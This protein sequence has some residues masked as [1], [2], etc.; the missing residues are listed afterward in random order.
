MIRLSRRHLLGAAMTAA[1]AGCGPGEWLVGAAAAAAGT[2]PA[3]G[4]TVDFARHVL[5]RC[6]FGARAGDRAALLARG[7]PAWLDGQ[8]TAGGDRAMERLLDDFTV[9]QVPAGEAYEWKPAVVQDEVIRGCLLRAVYSPFQVRE[10]VAGCWR[11]QFNVGAGKGDVAWLVA[12]Y[13]REVVRA[14]ALGRFADLL[15]ASLL[16]PAMLWYLDGRS[17]LREHPNENHARELLELH[18]LGADGGYSQRDVMEVARCLSGWTVRGVDRF[19]K[20]LVEFAPELHDDGPKEVLG[21]VIPAGLGA[22][23][24]DRVVALVAAH[25]AT[26]R[27]I[28]RRLCRRFIADAPPATAVAAAGAAFT[29]SG[30]DL[31]ATVRTVLTH[32]AFADPAIRG[33]KLKRPLHYLASCLRV[34]EARTRAEPELLTALARMGESPYQHPTPEGYPEN[35]E[36]WTGSLWWRWRAAYDLAHAHDTALDPLLVLGRTPTAAETTA[37]AGDLTPAE[38]RTILLAS[39]A[40][41]RC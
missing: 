19:R 31:A 38:R 40:F 23:D 33:G 20:G 35:A 26:A 11:D 15:R 39:P 18:G 5:D 37:L 1:L 12:A 2:D 28:A 3:P 8:L 9:L 13:D 34:L 6:T 29:A 7:F 16:H 25:P 32:D 30:G 17:N 21:T 22:S 4:D 36:A 41:Q 27:R 10:V 24:I 14:H